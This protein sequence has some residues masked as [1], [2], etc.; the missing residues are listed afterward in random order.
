MNEIVT[1]IVISIL[2]SVIT[3]RFLEIRVF[4]EIDRLEEDLLKQTERVEAF[5]KSST[6]SDELALTKYQISVQSTDGDANDLI[7]KYCQSGNI[8]SRLS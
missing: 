3:G 2:V 8:Y 4:H 5:E 1:C 7:K 6:P